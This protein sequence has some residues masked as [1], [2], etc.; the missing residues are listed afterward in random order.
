VLG[1][2]NAE[3]IVVNNE[4]KK[5]KCVAGILDLV[6][7][8]K[9]ASDKENNLLVRTHCRTDDL[10][11]LV[12]EHVSFASGFWWS[13]SRFRGRRQDML[14]QGRFEARARKPSAVEGPKELR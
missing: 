2:Q 5:I 11:E 12:R 4:G 6:K 13:R 1:D 10:G 3:R 14:G 7:A 9:H 8:L